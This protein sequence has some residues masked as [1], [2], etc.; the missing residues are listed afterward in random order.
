MMHN[1]HEIDKYII[2]P[3]KGMMLDSSDKQFAMHR[4][5]AEAT[6]YAIKK[7]PNPKLNIPGG[8]LYVFTKTIPNTIKIMKLY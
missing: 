6:A 5:A 4:N 7:C 1:V 3:A 8:K 2:L